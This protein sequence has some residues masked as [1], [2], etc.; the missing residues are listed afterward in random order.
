MS[1]VACFHFDLW[2]R[3]KCISF[4]RIIYIKELSQETFSWIYGCFFFRIIEILCHTREKWD[5][6][7]H[8]RDHEVDNV[9]FSR[10]VNKSGYKDERIIRNERLSKVCRLGQR[11]RHNNESK[12]KN[13]RNTATRKEPTWTIKKSCRLYSLE[14]KKK[15]IVFETMSVV[16]KTFQKL[17]LNY[18]RSINL[19]CHQFM[20][21]V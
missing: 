10:L 18:N 15:L 6:W 7:G 1:R 5:R 12:W 2:K 4:L 19:K 13:L 14:K 17:F 16:H 9:I 3:P 21:N 8:W 20:Q 11:S